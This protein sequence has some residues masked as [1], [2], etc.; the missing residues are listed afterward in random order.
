VAVGP[1]GFLTPPYIERL[2]GRFNIVDGQ[3]LADAIAALSNGA[4]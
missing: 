3:A 1:I 4:Q 2:G